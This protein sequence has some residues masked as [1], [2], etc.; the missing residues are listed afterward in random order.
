MILKYKLDNIK[1]EKYCKK[2]LI[3]L[4]QNIIFMIKKNESK[5]MLNN[6]YNNKIYIKI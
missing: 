2:I 3:I 1:L 4:T 6:Q 5:K